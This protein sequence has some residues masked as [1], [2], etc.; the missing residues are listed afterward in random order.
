MDFDKLLFDL[1][2]L[3]FV[4]SCQLSFTFYTFILSII[5][6]KSVHHLGHCPAY[7]IRSCRSHRT[8]FQS[9]HRE[10]DD[11]WTLMDVSIL[12]RMADIVPSRTLCCKHQLKPY[13]WRKRC[14][15][16]GGDNE[17]CL[18]SFRARCW[19][20]VVATVLVATGHSVWIECFPGI[21]LE[22]QVSLLKSVLFKS[23]RP[24]LQLKVQGLP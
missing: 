7:R 3:V 15:H 11:H 6:L 14:Y 9:L 4:F 22:A 21:L 13:T 18:Q 16:L 5:H 19:I 12:L 23:I 10:N 2:F 20:G 17:S 1:L 8:D 24:D